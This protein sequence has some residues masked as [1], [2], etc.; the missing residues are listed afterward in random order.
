MAPIALSNYENVGAGKRGSN[1]RSNS[2]KTL[3][4]FATQSDSSTGFRTASDGS[5]TL[6]FTIYA[7][8]EWNLIPLMYLV[9]YP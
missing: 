6:C 7:L 3:S 5:A 2:L 9:M 4:V 8:Q 1:S